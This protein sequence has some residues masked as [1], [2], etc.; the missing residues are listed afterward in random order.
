MIAVGRVAEP[1]RLMQNATPWTQ[2]LC[3]KRVAYYQ[4]ITAYSASPQGKPPK[5]PRAKSD[6]YGHEEVREALDAMFSG[7]CAYCEAWVSH[8]AW[9]HV[10]H[11]RPASVYPALA[12]R[13]SNLLY[14]CPRCNSEAKG[15]RFPL[16]PT[17]DTPEEDRANPCVRDDTDDALLVDP[18]RDN[19][20]DYLE[21]VGARLVAKID[22][23]SNAPYRRAICTI[24]VCGLNRINLAR[25]RLLFLHTVR[26][27]IEAYEKALAIGD[28][29]QI[30]KHRVYLK[31]Y[32]RPDS[33]YAG[34][35]RATLRECHI[36][37]RTL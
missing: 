2:E 29:D 4:Q 36:D 27:R 21:F 9:Q 28:G 16:A 11:F 24:A 31:R 12:Y 10:E 22:P 6:R 25:R 14:A 3:D 32:C 17:E 5:K 20:D 1:T 35:A 30:Q 23:V 19:P 26:L 15:G 37:W 7:K 8:V 13:W 18:C 34:M 33:E